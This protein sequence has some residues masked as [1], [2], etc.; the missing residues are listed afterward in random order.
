[1]TIMTV[2]ELIEELQKYAPQTQ[3]IMS[4]DSE[5]NLFGPISDISSGVYEAESTWNGDY[6]DHNH[7]AEENC[8]EDDEWEEMKADDSKSCICIWPIN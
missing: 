3:V 2:A 1:M 8:M 5:G 4:K 7:T 6:W